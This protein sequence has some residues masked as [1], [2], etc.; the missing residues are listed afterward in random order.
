M[1]RRV[2][3]SISVFL[4]GIHQP[5]EVSTGGALRWLWR[6][7][8]VMGRGL[9]VGVL[10]LIAFV[11]ISLAVEHFHPFLGRFYPGCTPELFM[12][13]NLGI[14]WAIGHRSRCDRPRQEARRCAA[15]P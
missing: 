10:I 3:R 12:P 8:T 15:R 9:G 7:I 14:C 2:E 1:L 4:F 6:Y 11:F 13:L 5:D